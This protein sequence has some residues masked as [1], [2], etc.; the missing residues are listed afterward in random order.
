MRRELGRLA[1]INI[2]PANLLWLILLAPWYGISALR[3]LTRGHS[4]AAPQ[5]LAADGGYRAAAALAG[6][7]LGGNPWHDDPALSGYFSRAA[8]DEIEANFILPGRTPERLLVRLMRVERA[9]YRA[10]LLRTSP[11]EPGLFE[12]LEVL[13]RPS[14]AR[15]PLVY[16]PSE[17]APDLDAWVSRCEQCGFDLALTPALQV[18]RRVNP[19]AH[20]D[21]LPAT[22]TDQCAACGGVLH[23]TRAPRAARVES[24]D[25]TYPPGLGATAAKVWRGLT[26]ATL[27]VC[28]GVVGVAASGSESDGVT[29]AILAA[30]PLGSVFGA[31]MTLGWARKNQKSHL[32]LIPG[33]ILGGMFLFGATLF[34]FEG[35]F[36]AL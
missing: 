2:L 32:W 29:A 12:G 35:I 14:A 33:F 1:L 26:I 23:M 30:A 3:T 7:P 10:V 11:S 20:P 6:P 9:C 34:F 28:C 19:A 36:P 4:S 15:P 18:A 17:A 24:V 25:E 8:P 16:V 31:W 5:S 13:V 27:V 22:L 21:Y